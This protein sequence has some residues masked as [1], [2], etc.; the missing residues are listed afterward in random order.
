MVTISAR[1]N[2]EK[3]RE[4]MIEDIFVEGEERP[5]RIDKPKIV[6]TARVHPG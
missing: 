4:E 5:F 2:C 1:A 3:V 6:L